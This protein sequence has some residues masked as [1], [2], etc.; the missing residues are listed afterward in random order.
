MLRRQPARIG[1]PPGGGCTAAYQ[2][3]RCGCGDHAGL[4][5]RDG[6][7]RA[8]ADPLTLA[9]REQRRRTREPVAAAPGSL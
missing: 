6:L 4:A 3:I 7:S 8:S 9:A 5:D 2:R 1:P